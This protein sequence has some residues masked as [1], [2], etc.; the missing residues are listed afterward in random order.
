MI[1]GL[2]RR[3]AIVLWSAFV[4]G[5][6]VVAEF[7]PGAIGGVE[8]QVTGLA[9]V[10]KSVPIGDVDGHAQ[11]CQ[12]PQ[13]RGL[14]WSEVT[15][16]ARAWLYASVISGRWGYRL[17]IG[18][19]QGHECCPPR[20]EP[21]LRARAIALE[22]HEVAG[23]DAAL[24]VGEDQAAVAELVHPWPG[25]RWY[26]AGGDDPVI[27]GVLGESVRAIGGGKDGLIADGCEALAGRV[28]PL[29]DAEFFTREPVRRA[30]AGYDFGYVFRAVR[31]AA[32][33]T[34][35]DLGDLLELD[36]DRISRIERGERQLRDITIIARVASRLGIPPALLGFDTGA[37]TVETTGTGDRREVDWVKRRDFPQLVAAI[38]LGVGVDALDLDRLAALLPAGP[39]ALTTTQVGAADVEAI[40]QAT[41]VLRG[42]QFTCGGGLARSTA[43]AQLRSVLPLLD[44]ASTPA[45]HERLL[46][47]T[48]DLGMVAAWTN[49]DVE[50]H[51]EARRLW[52]IALSVA[53]E[54]EDPAATDLIVKLL[55]AMTHQAL[56]L[57]R[58]QEALSMVQ[59]GYG[60]GAS[61]SQPVSAS[62]ASH[63]A[64]HQAW[65]HGALGDARACDRALGQAVENFTLADPAKAAPWAAHVNAAELAAQQGHARYTLSL[66]TDDSSH[67]ARA[68]PL[69]QE[70]VDAYG[71]TYTRS[72][73]VNLPG[74][75][76]AHVLTGDRD[77]AVHI[78]HHAVE[79]ITALAS[80]RAYDRLRTLDTVLQPHGT[81]PAVAEVRGR[82][83]AALAV[84]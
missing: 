84:V 46:V 19:T 76:G 16:L 79:E 43:V 55:L 23:A 60:A 44:T 69:L 2:F 64:S 45:V 26:G 81:D 17:L 35:Q 75:A 74:L 70:A 34:Q 28:D 9:V 40:E 41:A 63:L 5:A 21:T 29:L 38:A 1:R 42:W 50:R 67:A 6:G 10:V 33:L 22:E 73:A 3:R 80:P 83:H 12:K 82:I 57:R 20:I 65:C 24:E 48:A 78:G 37:A 66:A 61:R 59:L 51:D 72:R 30:L 25:D 52:V 7:C 49:Y 77:T 62:T 56:H 54:A 32:G 53:R 8:E 14:P 4:H 27:G 11:G 31:R 39:A 58:P 18:W 47:A 36:Q 68:V 13:D 71:P 15:D